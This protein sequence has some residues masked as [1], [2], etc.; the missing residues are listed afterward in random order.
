MHVQLAES[1]CAELH[2]VK[3]CGCCEYFYTEVRDTA[4]MEG[5]S[6]YVSGE[7]CIGVGLVLGLNVNKPLWFVRTALHVLEVR[8]Y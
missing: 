3:T 5:V 8:S 6:E 7:L 4:T 1:T 2:L